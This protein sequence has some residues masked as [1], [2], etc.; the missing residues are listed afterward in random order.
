[1]V[2]WNRGGDGSTGLGSDIFEG[3]CSGNVDL[4]FAQLGVI[5]KQSSFGRAAACQLE[6]SRRQGEN[7]GLTYVSFSKVTVADFCASGPSDSGVT[8]MELILPLV[9][10]VSSR[11]ND[12]GFLDLPEAE[13]ILDLLLG[14]LVGDALDVDCGRHCW[15]D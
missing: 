4:R 13:K 11:Y 2:I 12:F 7:G 8:E 9:S 15:C 5:Q 14:R 6:G 3:A 10:W 1:M